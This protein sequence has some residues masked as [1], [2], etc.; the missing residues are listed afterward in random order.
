MAQ[1]GSVHHQS[2]TAILLA[3]LIT[4]LPGHNVTVTDLDRIA[5]HPGTGTP[6]AHLPAGK[7]LSLFE[8]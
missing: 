2:L 6:E 8:I 1:H 5:R 3:T 4:Q 7:S